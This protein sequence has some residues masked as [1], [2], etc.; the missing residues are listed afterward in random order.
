MF[1]SGKSQDDSIVRCPADR[2]TPHHAGG[3]N[4]CP[5]RRRILLHL[6]T[7]RPGRPPDQTVAPS[8]F[9]DRMPGAQRHLDRSFDP[10]ALHG[11]QK[12]SVS[13]RT[14]PHRFRVNDTA[15]IS[16]NRPAADVWRSHPY[17]PEA[18]S[19]RSSSARQTKRSEIRARASLVGVYKLVQIQIRVAADR[20]RTSRLP[21]DFPRC[22]ENYLARRATVESK[23]EGS[24]IST[25]NDRYDFGFQICCAAAAQSAGIYNRGD[26]D[27]CV[28]NRR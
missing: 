4:L 8:S 1:S 11:F 21:N 14:I 17:R 18:R 12:L 27:A 20:C 19:L 7:P 5:A 3:D 23:A 13:R 10:S 22:R 25:N 6:W 26:V 24:C 28:S 16:T 15:S 2:R 9:S